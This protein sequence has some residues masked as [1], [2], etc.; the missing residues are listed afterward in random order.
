ME[1]LAKDS[2]IVMDRVVVNQDFPVI[3]ATV[4]QQHPLA[5]LQT[6]K[7]FAR[8]KEAANVANVSANQDLLAV[9]VNHPRAMSSTTLYAFTMKLACNALSIR[10]YKTSVP[11]IINYALHKIKEVLS[12]T[13]NFWMTLQVR[14]AI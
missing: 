12:I 9:I 5:K 4:K 13:L 1:V 11:I 8:I 7:R 3:N 6:A 2:V 14:I 10:V